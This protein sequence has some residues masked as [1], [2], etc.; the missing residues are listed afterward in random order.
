MCRSD[1]KT[2]HHPIRTTTEEVTWLVRGQQIVLW[3]IP[4]HHNG[5]PF[6]VIYRHNDPV[7]PI[8]IRN[9]N[10]PAVPYNI[11]ALNAANHA[12]MNDDIA[13]HSSFL[14]AIVHR[15]LNNINNFI[16]RRPW[17]EHFHLSQLLLVHLTAYM[18]RTR[19]GEMRHGFPAGAQCPRCQAPNGVCEA[20]RLYVAYVAQLYYYLHH[21]QKGG[22][23]DIPRASAHASGLA[24]RNCHSGD[25]GCQ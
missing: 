12:A 15:W 11:A 17:N 7:N 3:V 13:M 22:A 1:T 6:E 24:I 18:D 16:N 4:F 5:N 20:Y 8:M 25:R 23:L 21:P 2:P 9:N 10:G 19:V 14:V